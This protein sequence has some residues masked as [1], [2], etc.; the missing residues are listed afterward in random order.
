MDKKE[1]KQEILTKRE[2][3][4]QLEKVFATP[5]PPNPSRK[6]KPAQEASQT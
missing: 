1:K 6:K 4:R 5:V 3:E 2:F